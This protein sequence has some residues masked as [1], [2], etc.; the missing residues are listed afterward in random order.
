MTATAV[1]LWRAVCRFADLL[2]ERGV[3][4]LV[5]GVQVALFRT[6]DGDLHAVGN[7]DPFSGV[8]VLS[9][10]IVGTRGGVPVVSSPLFKQ[11]F[12]LTS[13]QC[14]DDA[15]KRNP[16]YGVRLREGVVEVNVRGPS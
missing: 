4:A 1:Q 10:G 9:R 8:S 2:P 11:A 13:G 12:D 6:F 14:L 5:D 15:D 7:V 3:A 16:V